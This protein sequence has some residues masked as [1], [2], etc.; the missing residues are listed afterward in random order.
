[1]SLL[2]NMLTSH[3]TPSDAL[4]L[5]ITSRPTRWRG[6]EV[7]QGCSLF[8]GAGMFGSLDLLS[9]NSLI[10]CFRVGSL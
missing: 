8:A 1:M 4:R 2:R 10:I 3:P 5:G 6:R 7:T 9:Q